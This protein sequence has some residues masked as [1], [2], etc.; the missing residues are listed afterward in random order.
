MPNKYCCCC[1]YQCA[2]L[3]CD[4]LITT[5]SLKTSSS[6][7]TKRP[8]DA[9]CL[10]VVSFT[11]SIVQYPESSFFIISY[12]GFGFTGAYN[13]ILFCCLRRKIEPCCHTYD[14]RSTVIVYSA[15]PYLVGLALW[16]IARGAWWSN[17]CIKQ[18]AGCRCNMQP[19]CSSY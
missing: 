5:V 18:K 4:M 16:V 14:S 7:V 12:F 10:S 19:W 6:A 3:C 13:L 8:R 2:K 1:Y 17:I 15:R 11:A 9:S